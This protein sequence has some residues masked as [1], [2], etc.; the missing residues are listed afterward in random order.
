MIMVTAARIA[1]MEKSLIPMGEIVLK[2]VV[3]SSRR[4]KHSKIIQI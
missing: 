2:A 1:G 3:G 4:A